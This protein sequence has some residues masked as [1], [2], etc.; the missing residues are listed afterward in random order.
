MQLHAIRLRGFGAKAA[1]ILTR[2]VGGEPRLTQ[3]LQ[4][5]LQPQ[6]VA[7]LVRVVARGTKAEDVEVC[8]LFENEGLMSYGC[9]SLVVA[10]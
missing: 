8:L 2:L 6:D 7:T 9:C 1:N 10:S 4:T 3:L 5:L